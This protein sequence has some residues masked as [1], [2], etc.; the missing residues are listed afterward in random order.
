MKPGF[1]IPMK[2]SHQDLNILLFAL[3]GAKPAPVAVSTSEHTCEDACP[4]VDHLD[5]MFGEMTAERKLVNHLNNHLR[6]GMFECGFLEVMD[7]LNAEQLSQE[8]LLKVQQVN[9]RLQSWHCEI[10][11]NADETSLLQE[12]FS[13]LPRSAWVTMPRTLWQLRKKLRTS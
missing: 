12:A 13:R 4:I 6:E 9:G 2:L 8:D 3:E 7:K 11:F 1:L 10:N 5:E